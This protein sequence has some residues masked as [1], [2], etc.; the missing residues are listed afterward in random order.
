MA[1][2][3]RPAVQAVPDPLERCST[4][5]LVDRARDGSQEALEIVCRRCLKALSRF[6]AGRLPRRV[7]G[8][9]ETQDLVSEALQKGL[10]RLN[11]IDLREPGA[12][13]AYLRKTLNNLIVDKVRAADRRP[14]PVSLDER[15][16]DDTLSPLERALEQE[17]L[18]LFDEA[19]LGLK[20]RDAALVMLRIEQQASYEEIAIELAV[21]TAN[22]ARLAVRRALYK[23]AVEMA[24]LSRAQGRDSTKGDAA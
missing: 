7:R 5:D 14:T 13:M 12:L 20:T 17:Q 11:E 3:P 16:M 4:I 9:L 19:L 15:Q 10:S 21:P 18:A 22:A 24:R 6:A 23:L 8:M 2:P 1:T